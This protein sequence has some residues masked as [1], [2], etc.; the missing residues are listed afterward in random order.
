M[1]FLSSLF[2]WTHASHRRELALAAF[3]QKALQSVRR[4][5]VLRRQSSPIFM[6]WR[7]SDPAAVFAHGQTQRPFSLFF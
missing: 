2:F 4:S 6:N 5:H 7:V 3:V 1:P